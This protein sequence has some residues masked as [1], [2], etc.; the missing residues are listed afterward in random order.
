MGAEIEPTAGFLDALP[1]RQLV[2]GQSGWAERLVGLDVEDGLAFT[3]G[4]ESPAL[5][6]LA[7]LST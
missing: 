4:P 2:R 6:L 5:S 1:V 7:A 3:E